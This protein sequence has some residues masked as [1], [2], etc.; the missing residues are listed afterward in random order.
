MGQSHI[1]S[2]NADL[3]LKSNTKENDMA[4]NA[5]PC[6]PFTIDLQVDPPSGDTELDFTLEKIC[7]DDGSVGW[8][9][10]FELD[11]KDNTG[12]LKPVVKLDIDVNDEDKDKAA[13]T[14]KHGLD[15]NQRA[16]ANVTAQTADS[17]RTGDAT[18]DDVQAQ[19][20]QVIPARDP[21]SPS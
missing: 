16:Q 13:A 18:Q 21:N 6:E 5:T 12:T 7:N 19:G 8:E 3:D 20:S 17:V 9:L 14:A 2:T 15:E 4:T 10:H 1:Q 11:E